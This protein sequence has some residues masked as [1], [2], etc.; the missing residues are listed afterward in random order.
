MFYWNPQR[1]LI[2]FEG[3]MNGLGRLMRFI[4]KGTE[5]A[6][7]PNICPTEIDGWHARQ[8]QYCAHYLTIC[9]RWLLC[10]PSF[11]GKIALP[12]LPPAIIEIIPEQI[13]W[14]ETELYGKLKAVQQWRKINKPPRIHSILPVESIYSLF[15]R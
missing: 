1:Q 9:L 2:H 12:S 8:A 15:I 10:L 6:W 14:N 7:Q 13:D 5:I 11:Q 3:E 4:S